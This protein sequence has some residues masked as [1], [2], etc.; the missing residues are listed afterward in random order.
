VKVTYDKWIHKSNPKFPSPLSVRNEIL[1]MMKGMATATLCPA[2]SIY[3]AH[4]GL[5]Q[6]YC[7]LG[8]YGMG[9]D[10]FQFFFIW[11]GTDLWEFYYHRLGHTTPSGWEKHKHHHVFYNPSPFAVIADEY[12][13]QFVRAAPLVVFPI[14]LPIN[15]DIM[16]LEFAVFF[17][18]YGV[19]LHWGY[20][21]ESIDAHHPFINTSFQHYIHHAKSVINKPFHTGF[22]FK[23]WDQLAGSIYTDECV[24]AKC[25]R[26]K[27]LRTREQ[28]K[29]VQLPDYSVL[30]QP[31]FWLSNPASKNV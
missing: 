27:G 31:S 11:I 26:G 5:S 12:V 6:A 23:I 16:F 19:Y 18:A 17:Y 1:Q 21:L 2:I 10:I 25:C 15:M 22:F 7:G 30:L 13:D 14:V 4:H 3:L 20:E 29:Q 8:K 9:Y 28:F 24:C